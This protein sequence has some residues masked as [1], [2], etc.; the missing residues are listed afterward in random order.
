MKLSFNVQGKTQPDPFIFRD[1]DGKFYY[2]TEEAPV[3]LGTLVGETVTSADE[4][5]TYTEY[6]LSTDL[7]QYIG[8]TGK[9]EGIAGSFLDLEKF[10]KDNYIQVKLDFKEIRVKD[11]EDD[12]TNSKR[13]TALSILYMSAEYR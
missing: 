10:A 2:A 9:G 5:V 6:Q 12:I 1:D 13:N 8:I 4:K 11:T 7:A 3:V